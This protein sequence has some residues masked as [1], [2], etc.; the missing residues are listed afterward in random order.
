MKSRKRFGVCYQKDL[1]FD[2]KK[3]FI[4]FEIKKFVI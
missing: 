3:K 4:V 2:I 1:L